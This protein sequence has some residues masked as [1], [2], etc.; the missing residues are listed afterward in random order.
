M[1]QITEDEV[2]AVKDAYE[3][4]RGD[5]ASLIEPLHFPIFEGMK[6]DMADEGIP[7]LV[8]IGAHVSIWESMI[9]A[10][11]NV[12]RFSTFIV[13]LPCTRGKL[14]NSR[15]IS[16]TGVMRVIPHQALDCRDT[17]NPDT[18]V[19]ESRIVGLY[20]IVIHTHRMH[21]RAASS[22]LFRHISPTDHIYHPT[23]RQND[24]ATFGTPNRDVQVEVIRVFQG[25]YRP[26]PKKSHRAG[27]IMLTVRYMYT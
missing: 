19:I 12:G 23:R 9:S 27:S 16:G 22:L 8:N 1:S 6:L 5:D 15:Y 21:N 14:L 26:A 17:F 2:D 20:A 3:N 11:K 24:I 4:T 7:R 13:G 25:C 10:Y 18:G